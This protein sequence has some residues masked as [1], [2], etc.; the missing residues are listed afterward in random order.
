M[1]G[2][3]STDPRSDRLVF[4]AKR[5]LSYQVNQSQCSQM[6]VA[7]TSL[8]TFFRESLDTGVC[9]VSRVPQKKR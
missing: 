5:A 3:A 4:R 8:S 7:R 1:F 6:H 9:E 2:N